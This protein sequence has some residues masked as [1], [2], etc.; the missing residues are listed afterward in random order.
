MS[1]PA[2]RGFHCAVLAAGGSRRLG[3]PKQLVPVGDVPLVRHVVGRACASHADRVAVIV[4]A[5]AADV[6]RVLDG[7]PVDILEN[8]GWHE[9]MASSIRLATEWAK[10]R[11]ADALVLALGDQ[12]GLTPYHL[13]RIA[14][15]GLERASAVGSAY[16]GIVGVPAFFDARLFGRLLSLKGDRGASSLLAEVGASAVPWPAGALD[17]DTEF[18]VL[19]LHAKG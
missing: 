16:D 9:G 17:V 8:A 12:P 11:R 1:A 3:R 7:L 2:R 5:H 15:E 6:S 13:D 18:D 19:R 14:T 10:E 4:G